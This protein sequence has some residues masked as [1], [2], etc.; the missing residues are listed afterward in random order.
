[1]SNTFEALVLSQEEGLHLEK[2]EF[3]ELKPG[4][5]LVKIKAAALNHRDLFINEGKYPNIQYPAILGSD[6][7][8]IVEAVADEEGRHWKGEEV[9]INPSI[10]W[11]NDENA[12]SKDFQV[13]G[14]PMNG[15]FARYVVVPVKNLFP[16]PSHLG[17]EQAAAL[18]LAGLTA[19]RA[20]MVKG[21][22]KPATSILITGIGGGVAQMALQFA[23][24]I[25]AEIFVTSGDEDKLE[26]AFE[27][28]ARDG[29][30][31]K[32]EEWGKQ[33]KQKSGGIHLCIDGACGDQMNDIVNLLKPGGRL[34]FYGA[35]LGRPSSLQ[36]HKIFWKQ[37]TI[38]GST[39]G[40]DQN[41]QDMLDFVAQHKVIPT[42]DSVRPF[43]DIKSAFEAMKSGRQFGKLVVKMD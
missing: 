37:L 11:G 41:F 26:K 10:Q 3:P 23:N 25:N 8:G 16:K 7:S 38:E 34:V 5:A 24:A 12:Q 1:M 21:N 2:V 28:G 9:I 30:N 22:P 4:E 14:M 18:P 40:S 27:L 35:T 36:V 32:N 6:G 15:T 17:F 33:L 42:V 19:Y 39:M 20:T 31:Y 43:E 29:A 13:F